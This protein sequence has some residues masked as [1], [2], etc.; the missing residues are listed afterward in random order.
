M[1][2]DTGNDFV[3]LVNINLNSISKIFYS[4]SLENM[5]SVSDNV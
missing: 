1:A 2:T 4:V 5:R 3:P